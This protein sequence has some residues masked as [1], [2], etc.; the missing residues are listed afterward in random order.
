MKLGLVKLVTLL[1]VI[2]GCVWLTIVRLK[3]NGR[4]SPLM[5]NVELLEHSTSLPNRGM[6]GD[7]ISKPA[8]TELSPR[9]CNN[10]S[11]GL[12][13]H[14]WKDRQRRFPDAIIIGAK[15]S[16]TSALLAMLR[17]HPLIDG[18]SFETYFFTW[19]YKHGYPWY[20]KLMPRTTPDQV[21]I[22]KTPGYF[23]SRDALENLYTHSLNHSIKFILVVREPVLRS[24]SD[25]AWRVSY[26]GRQGINVSSYEYY[27]F[28]NH[29][30]HQKK[31]SGKFSTEASEINVSM[32]D[33]HYKMWVENL[34]KTRYSL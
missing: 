23:T 29:K 20:L 11:T 30:Q 17:S 16:G 34:A 1:L 10:P 25:Y 12:S 21:T 24:I 8:T 32:Y 9:W 15:K 27:V 4:R 19:R 6:Y 5:T 33:V 3:I 7:C 18:P 14:D 28:A 13:K 31:T 22:E 26:Y 2:G